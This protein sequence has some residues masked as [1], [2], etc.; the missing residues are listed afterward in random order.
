MELVSCAA[1]CLL[2]LTPCATLCAGEDLP[3]GAER[4]AFEETG[5]AGA[6]CSMVTESS[7]H[8]N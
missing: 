3:E 8:L 1:C 2:Q 4:E 7:M 5:N 6:L